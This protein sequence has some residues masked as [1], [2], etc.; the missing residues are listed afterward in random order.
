MTTEDIVKGIKERFDEEFSHVGWIPENK[1]HILKFLE[2]S[3]LTALKLQKET[4]RLP[5]VSR[6]LGCS[7]APS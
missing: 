5:K 2:Q 1:A 7:L 6:C 3:I 4:T